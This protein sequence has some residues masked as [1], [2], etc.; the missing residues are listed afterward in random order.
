MKPLL[1]LGSG[2]HARVLISLLRRLQRPMLGII[3]PH[4]LIGDSVLGLKVLGNDKQVLHYPPEQI[5]L[6]NG[7]GSLPNETGIRSALFNRFS[8]LGYHFPALIDS[9]ALIAEEVRLEQGVQVMAGVIIQT[10]TKIAEN[11]IVNSGAIIEHDAQIGPHGHIAPGAVLSGNVTLGANV[12]IGTGA[13]IIQGISI[14]RGSIIG[15][16]AT[17]TRDVGE[18]QIVYPAR[19]HIEHRPAELE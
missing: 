4:R 13:S 19:V 15:A 14:G 9:H 10:G 18:W 12:H 5:E 17:V 8:Q 7:V 11:C 1:I 3:D 6:V 16:G 2:G